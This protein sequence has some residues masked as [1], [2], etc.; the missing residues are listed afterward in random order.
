MRPAVLP[1][2]SF[3]PLICKWEKCIHLNRGFGD[4]KWHQGTFPGV[5]ICLD[6]SGDDSG[7]CTRKNPPGYTHKIMHF[8]RWKRPLQC[9][10]VEGAQGV[11]LSQTHPF[12]PY[13]LCR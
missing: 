1:S 10:L 4:R 8:T 3:G 2:P 7:A 13:S 11:S 5:E 12:Q 9:G 6:L